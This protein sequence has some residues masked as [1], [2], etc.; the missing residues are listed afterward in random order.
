[1][2]IVRIRAARTHR[3]LRPQ[4]PNADELAAIADEM[5]PSGNGASASKSASVRPLRKIVPFEEGAGTI[6]AVA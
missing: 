2:P 5:R 4:P 3:R 1:V 6:A